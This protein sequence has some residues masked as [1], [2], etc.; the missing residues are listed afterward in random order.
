MLCMVLALKSHCQAFNN[1]K[2]FCPG[3]AIPSQTSFG[4]LM[5]DE[6]MSGGLM[7]SEQMSG[8]QM[9]GDQMYGDQMSSGQMSGE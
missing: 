8:E 5:S 1:R 2:A 3:C 6:Q 7:S 4:E 9:S